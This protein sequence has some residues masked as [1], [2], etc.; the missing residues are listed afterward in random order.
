MNIRLLLFAALRELTG[1]SERQLRLP[2]EVRSIGALRSH[3]EQAEPRLDGRLGSV[4][5]AINEQ[6]VD[7]ASA[8]AEGDVVA[9]IP[10]VTGG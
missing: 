8:L 7:D 1:S 10:P 3:L 4:R 2:P 5:F 6:F 9:L